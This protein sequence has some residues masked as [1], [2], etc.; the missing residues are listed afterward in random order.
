[1]KLFVG[2]HSNVALCWIRG[3]RKTWKPWVENRVVSIRKV[4]SK[5]KWHHIPGES[6]PADIPT[7]MVEDFQDC[8]SDK[9]T[10]GPEILSKSVLFVCLW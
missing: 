2:R 6:N 1:M 10:Q 7:R 3:D 5:E 9:W 4:V 8:F